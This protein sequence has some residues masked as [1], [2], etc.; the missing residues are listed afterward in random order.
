MALITTLT[1]CGVASMA[2]EYDRL[3]DMGGYYGW[4]LLGDYLE[5]LSEDIG[6]DIAIDIIGLCCD[7]NH[8]ESADS[9]FNEYS[10]MIDCEKG[11]FNAMDEDGKLEVIREFLEYETT[12]V[13]C[14]DG[15]IIFA[16]F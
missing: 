6:E 3:A 14:E 16:A 8:Y 10:N 12:L 1:P 13:S 2:K 4:E 11:D 5:A 9:V 15:Y 7:Y